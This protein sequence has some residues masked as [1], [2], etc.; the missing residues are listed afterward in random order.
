ME[1][2]PEEYLFSLG[3]SAPWRKQIAGVCIW[4]CAASFLWLV[5]YQ[6]LASFQFGWEHTLTDYGSLYGSASRAN[7][8]LNPYLDHPLVF[9]IEGVDRHGFGTPLQGTRV[10]AINLN[11]PVVLYPFRLLARLNPDTSYILW[12]IISVGLFLASIRIV[13]QMYPAETLRIRILWILAMGAVWYTF[14]LGQ[15]YMILLFCASLA[16]MAM[17]KHNWLVAGISIGVICAIKPNLL[18]WP[19]LL[20]A[21][22]SK[23]IGLTAFATT[24]LLSA[25]P[26]LL[27]GPI[28]YR[29]WLAACR[30][31]NGYELPGNASLLAMFS[32]AGF[33]QAGFALTVLLLAA[34]TVWVFITKPE[35]L[36]ASEIGILAS[37]I[38]GPI[39]WLG[40][41]ILLIPVLYGKSMS[42]LTRIA[43]VLLCIPVWVAMANADTSRLTYI[44]LWAPNIYAIGLLAYNAI[45]SGEYREACEGST[46]SGT[47]MP[48]AFKNSNDIPSEVQWKYQSFA[49]LKD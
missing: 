26:L 46:E 8:H 48:V 22:K 42:S 20:I 31:F 47:R 13:L 12:S 33:P 49:P 19:G 11:P 17:R 29:E 21:G 38:A 45:R 30:G 16:W 1:V 34:V 41:T 25:I 14:H 4:F 10:K 7:L 35:P 32:R 9:H 24:G 15:I 27:Q 36:Y 44:L 6:A 3:R 40:Y 5:A 43:C 2:N 28:I 37:L 23:K 39:S 18:V